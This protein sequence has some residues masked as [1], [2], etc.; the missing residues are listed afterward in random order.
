MYFE[1]CKR[2]DDGVKQE[3]SEIDS[4]L[5]ISAVVGASF[6]IDTLRDVAFGDTYKTTRA[7]NGEEASGEH[8]ATLLEDFTNCKMIWVG[9]FSSEDPA[10]SRT[11]A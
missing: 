6:M 3:D 8:D 1:W 2:S 7:E 5:S 9:D 4:I 10:A 11:S